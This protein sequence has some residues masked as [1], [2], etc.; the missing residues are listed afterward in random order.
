MLGRQNLEQVGLQRLQLVVVL[1][2]TAAEAGAAE[3]EV[4]EVVVPRMVE[5]EAE[6]VANVAAVVVANAV[7]VAV[8][9]MVDD[10]DGAGC[11]SWTGNASAAERGNHLLLKCRNV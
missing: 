4:A 5:A 8:A 3:V 9:R 7:A 10:E 11:H 6:V 2:V 1:V